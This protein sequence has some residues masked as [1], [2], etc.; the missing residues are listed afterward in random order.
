MPLELAL[1]SGAAAL[2][3]GRGGHG[4]AEQPAQPLVHSQRVEDLGAAEAASALALDPPQGLLSD[5][6]REHVHR[7]RV[8]PAVL[9]RLQQHGGR[10]RQQSRLLGQRP[11]HLET[12]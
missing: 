12:R 3:R 10:L 8:A 4:E 5:A 9:H 1:H 11:S 2:V 6:A 7:G